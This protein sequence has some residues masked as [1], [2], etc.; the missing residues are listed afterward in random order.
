[1]VASQY[2]TLMRRGASRTA[3]TRCVCGVLLAGLVAAH[4]G[5]ARAQLFAYVLE[6]EGMTDKSATVDVVDLR[7]RA[8]Q[9]IAL[10]GDTFAGAVSSNNSAFLVRT[11][12]DP[13]NDSAPTFAL[14]V[15]DTAQRALCSS[16]PR[17]SNG[18]VAI[19]PTGPVAYLTEC[20]PGGV[21]AS[22][23]FLT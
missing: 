8:V 19:A 1:R 2:R 14:A 3:V 16:L 4:P 9:Q 12:T 15:F 10:G 17:P 21:V 11:F 5:S 6:P 20:R 23:N 22:I 13:D 7:T 18:G